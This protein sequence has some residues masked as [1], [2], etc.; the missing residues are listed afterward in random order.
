MD[1][2]D[3]TVED[4]GQITTALHARMDM[5]E[6]NAQEA[7]DSGAPAAVKY[8]RGQWKLARSTRSKV[9]NARLVG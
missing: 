4:W 1:I 2:T 7:F 6:A 3:L 9:L 8:W 5:C